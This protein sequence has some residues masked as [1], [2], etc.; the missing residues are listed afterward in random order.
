[1]V[2]V[3]VALRADARPAVGQAVRR[4]LTPIDDAGAAD[5][6]DRRES[7]PAAAIT[8]STASADESKAFPPRRCFTAAEA[9]RLAYTVDPGMEPEP[10][11]AQLP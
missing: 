2:A 11:P 9:A 10:T 5:E 6:G 3:A 1:M 7:P 4:D 8:A